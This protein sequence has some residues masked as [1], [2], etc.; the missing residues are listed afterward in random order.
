[1]CEPGSYQPREAASNCIACEIGKY[2]QK[3]GSALVSDCVLC[4]TGKTTDKAGATAP[5]LCVISSEILGG[6][7]F[8]FG[9]AICT[10]LAIAC[11][12]KKGVRLEKNAIDDPL[13]RSS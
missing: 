5:D 12:K 2:S 4:G 13:L 6:V 10:C 9:G 11:T 7:V 1:M 3:L 8:V